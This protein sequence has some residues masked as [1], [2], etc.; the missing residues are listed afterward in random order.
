MKSKL[1]LLQEVDTA[2]AFD[3][4][5]QSSLD[6]LEDLIPCHVDP[7]TDLDDK[8]DMAQLL[9][10]LENDY[11][12]KATWDGLRK[13]WNMEVTP[14]YR[15]ALDERDRLQARVDYLEAECDRIS[16]DARAV[17]AANVRLVEE[18]NRKAVD[19]MEGVE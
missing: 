5:F 18:R 8:P 7:S 15:R 2:A 4:M 13:F 3:N 17:L 10:C 1:F 11:G 6:N 19:N 16:N 12:I 9:R 14:D